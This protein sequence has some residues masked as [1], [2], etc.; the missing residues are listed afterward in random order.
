MVWLIA[1]FLAATTL[2]AQERYGELRGEVTDQTGAVLPNTKLTI[3]NRETNRT[4]TA[5]TTSDGTYIVRDVDPGRY[6]ITFEAPGFSRY[7]IA[8]VLVVVEEAFVWTG[9]C[10]SEGRSRPCRLPKTLR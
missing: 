9:R 1:L 7:E 3:R 5:Q 8:E 10:R 2:M 6:S 4:Y